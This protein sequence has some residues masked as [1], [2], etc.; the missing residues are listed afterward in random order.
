MDMCHGPL[1]K[2]IVLF[3]LPLMFSYILQLA[4]NAVDL[5][6][7]GQYT[8]HKALAA[9]GSTF[10]INA[11]VINLFIG[12]SV[13]GNVV[14]ATRMG[15]RDI[16]GMSRA[17]NTSMAVGL[18]GGI[19][20][21]IIGLAA[22]RPMLIWM[23]TPADILPK[24]CAYIWICFLGIPSIMLYNFGCAIL[25]AV[26]DTRRPLYYLVIA[27]VVN[28]LLNLF[29][30]IVCGMNVEG[31]AIATVISHVVSAIL[32][33]RTVCKLPE[34]YRLTLAKFKMDPA[35]LKEIVHI[36]CPA[37]IQSSCFAISN[38]LIQSA[39]NSFG[40]VAM[41]AAAVATVLEGIIYVGSLSFHQTV[42]TFV[43]Q[44]LGGRKYKRILHSVLWC[45]MCAFIAN[46]AIGY[47]FF[48]Q[49]KFMIGLFNPDPEVIRE[50]LI[51]AKCL[52]LFYFLCGMMDVTSGALRGL[53]YSISSAIVSLVGACA[54]RSLWVLFVL[55]L[56][57]TMEFLLLSYPV[58]WFMVGAVNIVIFILAYRKLVR[59][60]CARTVKWSQN[61]PGIPRGYRVLGSSK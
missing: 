48:W 55:P 31:V 27:G 20:L 60:Q 22:A 16:P 11:L 51:R 9:I 33:V 35:T 61:G 58:S 6:V 19:G 24:S 2:K 42:T 56:H 46:I 53:G 13:G 50:G 29:F 15:A 36:G 21:M 18:W 7:I 23:G 25:R 57:R 49:G 40:A 10:N 34:E 43:A 5:I 47:I 39:I 14:A 52:F 26:G 54:F 8:D 32:V 59:T 3:A 45:Y 1:L 4:F 44:N 38:L 30:V 17:V 37:G 41:A 12:F 28:V